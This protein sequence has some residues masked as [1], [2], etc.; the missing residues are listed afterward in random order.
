MSD[1]RVRPY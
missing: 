1:K